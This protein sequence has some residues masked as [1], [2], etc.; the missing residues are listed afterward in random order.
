MRP[1]IHKLGFYVLTAWAAITLNFAIP[2]LMPGNA[3]DGYLAQ[4]RGR[5]SPQAIDALRIAFGG[6]THQSLFSQY[7]SYLNQLAHLQFGTSLTYF[8]EPVSTVIRQSLP[9]TVILVGLTTVIAFALGTLLGVIAGWRRGGRLD[10]ILTPFGAFVS[11]MPYFWLGLIVVTVFAVNLRWLPASGGYSPNQTPGFDGGFLRSAVSHAVL[12][13]ITIIVSAV[14]AWLLGMRN[15]MLNTLGED[16]IMLARAKGLSNSRI[17]FAYA[18][19]NAILPNIAGFAL[20]IGFVVSGAILT[21]VV[22]SYPGIGDVLFQAIN[23]RDYPL[24]QAVFLIIT[25][26]VLLANLVAD[27]CYVWLDPRARRAASA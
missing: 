2:R 5:V 9:W 16:Y 18:A 1:L 12:P 13:A 19:R 10:G 3:V 23:N 25:L 6:S 17:M 20:S 8:P 7:A 4:M 24:M 11:S 26:A 22:F 21:E 27:I 15:M 14:G